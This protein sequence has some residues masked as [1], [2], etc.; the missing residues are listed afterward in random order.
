MARTEWQWP[1]DSDRCHGTPL[2]IFTLALPL[3]APESDQNAGVL[4][5]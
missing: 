3:N 2:L 4:Q 1:G 5:L